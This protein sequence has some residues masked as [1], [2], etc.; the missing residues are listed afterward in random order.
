MAQRMIERAV[1]APVPFAWVSGDELDGDNRSLRV[2]L[3]QQD[4]HFVLAVRGNRYVWP[5]MGVP[6]TAEQL[7]T[8]LAQQDWTRLSAGDGA[9]GPRLYDWMRIPL[10]SWQMA[11]ERWLVVRRSRSDG[12]LAHHV[13]Y[14][15]PG[16]QLQEMV[17]VAGMR[18]TVEECFEAA[19][20]EVG[21]DQYEVRSWHGWR[22]HIAHGGMSPL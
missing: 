8:T 16:T 19:K 18:W 5:E 15:A 10:P 12:K 11:G 6:A 21:L 3:E 14:A 4:L 1:A 22:R 7:A 13:C 17:R 20:G 9:K 2:W